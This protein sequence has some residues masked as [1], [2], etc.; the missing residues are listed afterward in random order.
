MALRL[1]DSIGRLSEH[2]SA[3]VASHHIGDPFCGNKVGECI[4][5]EEILYEVAPACVFNG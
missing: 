5:V 2:S 1:A 4:C 3:A